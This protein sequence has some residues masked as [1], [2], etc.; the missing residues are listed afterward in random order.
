[1]AHGGVLVARKTAPTRLTAWLSKHCPWECAAVVA[2]T[3]N[4]STMLSIT[5][6]GGPHWGCAFGFKNSPHIVVED[7][8]PT[9]Y[10][11]FKTQSMR[12]LFG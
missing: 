8:I 11:A 1:M 10:F 3:T 4:L 7:T 6:Y 12:L 5:A 2:D 9:V